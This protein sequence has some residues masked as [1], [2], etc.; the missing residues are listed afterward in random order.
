MTLTKL[1]TV[2]TFFKITDSEFNIH[3]DTVT[4]SM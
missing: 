3:T 1:K 4:K 2:I